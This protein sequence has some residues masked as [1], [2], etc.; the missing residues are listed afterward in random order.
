MQHNLFT[1]DGVEYNQETKDLV[2]KAGYYISLLVDDV[3]K[4]TT[5]G[6]P[7]DI[8]P[9]SE[10]FIASVSL[11]SMLILG[12]LSLFGGAEKIIMAGLE[13]DS[14]EAVGIRNTKSVARELA[15]DKLAE[16][17]GMH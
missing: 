11:A 2:A 5:E 13:E 17:G 12:T 1:E 14:A 16:L 3:Y 9:R 7:V 15:K 10:A 4:D 6:D 8:D